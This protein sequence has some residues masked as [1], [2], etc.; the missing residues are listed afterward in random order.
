MH[1]VTLCSILLLAV[2]GAFYEAYGS[3]V[4]HLQLNDAHLIETNN[5]YAI[6]TQNL[7]QNNQWAA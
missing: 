3:Q 1:R 4:R 6:S 5:S 7:L 2:V